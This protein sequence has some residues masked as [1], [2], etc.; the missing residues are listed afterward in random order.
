MPIIPNSRGWAKRM[1]MNLVTA[2]IEG[3]PELESE[4]MFKTNNKQPKQQT[5][6]QTK[7]Q[8]DLQVVVGT[9]LLSLSASSW[10]GHC[11]CLPISTRIPTLDVKFH[12]G[13]LEIQLWTGHGHCPQGIHGV[14]GKGETDTSLI[15]TQGDRSLKGLG[16]ARGT[17]LKSLESQRRLPERHDAYAKEWVG[18][19]QVKRDWGEDTPHRWS[20]KEWVLQR[21]INYIPKW[22]VDQ[23]KP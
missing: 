18:V 12:V 11:L 9:P 21:F 16:E 14:I 22:K 8:I 4:T 1:A 5:N 19:S 7:P 6:P 2:W 10:L 17:A 20:L 13:Y 15:I 23:F 3:H